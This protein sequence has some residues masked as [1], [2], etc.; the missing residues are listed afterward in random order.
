MAMSEDTSGCPNWGSTGEALMVEARDGAQQSTITP[1]PPK[2][3]IIC[4][5]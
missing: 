5:G 3:R 4:A 2:Q 1:N